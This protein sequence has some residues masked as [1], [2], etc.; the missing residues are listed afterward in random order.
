MDEGL[1]VARLREGCWRVCG[2][3][4]FHQIGK[5]CAC[6]GFLFDVYV[7]EVECH[8]PNGM[9]FLQSMV[10]GDFSSQELSVLLRCFLL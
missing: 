10:L 5:E 7:S 6:S 3:V 8:Y 9:W 4:A 2:V 1:E